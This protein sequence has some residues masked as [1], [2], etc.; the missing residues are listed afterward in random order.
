M[1]ESV[2]MGELARDIRRICGDPDMVDR[3]GMGY[4]GK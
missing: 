4:D 2:K 1:T 3:M